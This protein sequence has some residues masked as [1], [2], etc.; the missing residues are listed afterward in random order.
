MSLLDIT[1]LPTAENSAIHLHQTD[2][3]AVARVPLSPGQKLNVDGISITVRD[4]VPAGH[5][6]ALRLIASGENIVRYGQV[7]GRARAA[8]EPGNHVHTQNVSFEEI[9]FAYEFPSVDLPV[10]GSKD[11]PT[12]LGYRRADGR[13]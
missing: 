5:K 6:V 1:K 3:I 12:F 8:I 13:V 4:A 2:N 10:P 7:M 11:A 9:A